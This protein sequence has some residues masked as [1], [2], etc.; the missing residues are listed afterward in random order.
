MCCHKHLPHPDATCLLHCSEKGIPFIFYFTM[1]GS[2]FWGQLFDS[3]DRQIKSFS[4]FWS[5]F[6]YRSMELN[7]FALNCWDFHLY[8]SA[9]Y[10]LVVFG[11]YCLSNYMA[12]FMMQITEALIFLYD[13]LKLKQLLQPPIIASV[14]LILLLNWFNICLYHWFYN[15]KYYHE[16]YFKVD[17]QNWT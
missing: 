9:L 14:S 7:S 17:L 11:V 8:F 6:I 1:L 15:L 12:L 10:L 2:P 16:Q 4:N 5:A 3:N 13:K